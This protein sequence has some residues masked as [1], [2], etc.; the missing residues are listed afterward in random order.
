M[1]LDLE[2]LFSDQQIVTVTASSTNVL[3]LPKDLAKGNPVPLLLQVTEAFVGAT[4][5]AVSIRTS[6]TVSAGALVSPTVLATTAA[7]PVASLKAG[8]KFP[9]G[10]IPQGTLNYVDLLYTVVGTATAGKV[11]SGIVFN[12][13]GTR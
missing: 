7:I 1:I 13:P 10:H 6:A 4:S 3:K 5:V 8:Y 12:T 9:L 11:T 2:N